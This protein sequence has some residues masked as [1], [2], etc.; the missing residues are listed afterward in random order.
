MKLTKNMKLFIKATWIFF[1]LA[2]VIGLSGILIIEEG[3]SE[4]ITPKNYG[5]S[6][7]WNVPVPNMLIWI[8]IG[9]ISISWLL[10][11]VGFTIIRN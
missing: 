11:G 3:F 1:A 7:F 6:Y 5:Y 8:L 2:L 9:C 4:P 10:H